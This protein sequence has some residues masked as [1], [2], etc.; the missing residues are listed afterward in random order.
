MRPWWCGPL[1]DARSPLAD[2]AASLRSAGC[3]SQSAR[4]HARH[5]RSDAATP[6][7]YGLVHL[8]IGFGAL[9]GTRLPGIASA[10]GAA[11]HRRPRKMAPTPQW[12]V[13]WRRFSDDWAHW[14]WSLLAPSRHRWNQHQP[15]QPSLQ[16][17]AAASPLRP[18][19]SDELASRKEARRRSGTTITS[20]L[21]RK[22]IWR[23]QISRSLMPQPRT[24]TTTERATND[25]SPL[26]EGAATRLE[27][28][29]W[30]TPH[31]A[32]AGGG[33]LPASG[34]RF[35]TAAY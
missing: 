25:P 21:P 19:L 17:N 32:L 27:A 29:Y 30:R 33:T 31:G 7:L 26:A 12:G 10:G 2:R 18:N 8:C 6:I 3:D 20:V 16:R 11:I 14:F 4:N 1:P 9:F 23:R 22:A 35:L 13:L 15:S 5:R 34:E 28:W 24:P